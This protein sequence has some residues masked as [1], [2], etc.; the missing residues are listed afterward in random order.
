M[1]NKNKNLIST[2]SMFDYILRVALPSKFGENLTQIVASEKCGV[3]L[4]ANEE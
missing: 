3:C 1:R 2:V 4:Q